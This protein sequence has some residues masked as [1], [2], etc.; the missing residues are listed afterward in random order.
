MERFSTNLWV[1]KTPRLE[2][3]RQ[4]QLAAL[5]D[6]GMVEARRAELARRGIDEKPEKL[7]DGGHVAAPKP[8]GARSDPAL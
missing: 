7:P 5:N 2:A 3:L 1:K 4:A 6:P 8:P